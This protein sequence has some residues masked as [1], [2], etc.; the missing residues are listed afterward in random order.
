MR[1]GIPRGLLNFGIKLEGQIGSVFS[2]LR[3]RALVPSVKALVDQENAGPKRR[4]PRRV[5]SPTAGCRGSRR[6]RSAGGGTPRGM[7]PGN[8][9]RASRP[10]AL[11][12]RGA[13]LAGRCLRRRRSQSRTE[14][15]CRIERLGGDDVAKRRGRPE[16]RPRLLHRVA[17]RVT[18]ARV[19]SARSA[20]R[21]S[22]RARGR[23]GCRHRPGNRLVPSASN[24]ARCRRWCRCR[25]ARCRRTRL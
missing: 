14:T 21:F 16:R 19:A 17:G 9:G 23:A 6:N 1:P 13:Q 7:R 15:G 5:A 25:P 3:A 2:I 20:S 8:E 11:A 12:P 18:S 10:S 24:G 4:A 22:G